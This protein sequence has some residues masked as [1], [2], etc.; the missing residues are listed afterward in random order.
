MGLN[1]TILSLLGRCI[2]DRSIEV[3]MRNPSESFL[4]YKKILRFSFRQALLQP[5]VIPNMRSVP[6]VDAVLKATR[7]PVL[8]I[9]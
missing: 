5:G 9:W 3:L 8:S 6:S 1:G 7:S 2:E 4:N